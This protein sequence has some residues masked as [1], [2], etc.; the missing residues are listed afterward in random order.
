MIPALLIKNVQFRKLRLDLLSQFARAV[1]IGYVGLQKFHARVGFG[2]CA[3]SFFIASDDNDA[4]CRAR[5]TLRRKRA[6]D[7][8]VAAGD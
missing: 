5:E 2:D 3:Q 6:T 7:A 4:D 8:A 1:G